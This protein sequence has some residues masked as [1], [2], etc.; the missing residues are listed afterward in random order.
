DDPRAGPVN[1]SIALGI[2]GDVRDAE[3]KPAE[4]FAAYAKGRE[5]LRNLVAAHFAGQESAVARVRRLAAYFEQAPA[6][7]LKA[8][9][10]EPGRPALH[11][12]LVGFPRSG[13]TLLEQALA[14][15]GAVRTMEEVDCLGD[16]V[17]EYF[18]AQDGMARFAALGEE[19]L[20]KLRAQYWERVAASG[21]K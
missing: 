6:E 21:T 14:S 18:Y 20:E 1:Q 8:Q 4:A 10:A 2:L 13:T 9:P 12:F 7:A 16:T 17:G 5:L 15:H 19:A 3:G 11:A